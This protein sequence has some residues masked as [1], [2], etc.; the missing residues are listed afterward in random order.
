MTKHWIRWVLLGST[1]MITSCGEVLNQI[2]GPRVDPIPAGGDQLVIQPIRVCDSAGGNCA[3]ME[4]FQAVVDKVW[5]QAGIQVTFLPPNQLNNSAYLDVDNNEFRDLSFSGAAGAFGRHPRSTRDTGPINMWFVVDINSTAGTNVR[6]YGNAWIGQNGVLISD[7]ILSF[8][9]SGRIDVIAHEIGHNLGLRH[10]TLGAG[11]ANNIMSDGNTRA[12][13]STVDDIFPD[14]ARLGQL[15]SAQ[16][17]RARSSSLLTSAV[18]VASVVGTSADR[19][20]M[21]ELQADRVDLFPATLDMTGAIA[22]AD[23]AIAP[24]SQPSASVPEPG[25]SAALWL[26][27]GLLGVWKG[28]DRARVTHIQNSLKKNP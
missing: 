19:V 12:I 4:F 25:V 1:V 27:L 5:A 14:G 9:P 24:T 16:I 8:G 22:S 23:S 17:N 21:P 7:D 15:T 6:Q 28:Q 11:G 26:G 2:L 13:P 10:T 18:G 3:Q 20:G